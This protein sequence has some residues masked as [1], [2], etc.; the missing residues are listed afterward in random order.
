MP[1]EN[2]RALNRRVRNLVVVTS[3]SA[4]VLVVST[5]AWFI[6]MQTVS[7]SS[8]D[9]EIAAIDGLQLSLDGDTWGTTIAINSGNFDVATY[10]TNTNTWGGTDGLT[11]VST[12]GDIDATTSKLKLYEKSSLTASPGGYRLMTSRIANTADTE[13]DGYVAFDLFV[14]NQSGAEYYSAFEIGNEEAIYLTNDSSVTVAA[15][16]VADTGIENSVRVA[17]AQIGRVNASDETLTTEQ[18]QGISCTDD[19]NVTSICT[20]KAT[21]WEPNDVAHEA[22]AINWYQT[23]CLARTGADVTDEASFAGSC[24]TVVNGIAYDT[25]AVNAPIDWSDNVDVYDGTDYNTYASTTLLSV[26]PDVITDSQKYL[27]GT[28]RPEFIRL[29]PN[30]ITKVRVYVY[31]EGQDIDNYDFSAIGKAI[32]VQFGFTKQRYTEGDIDYDQSNTNEGE[33]PNAATDTTVP[34]IVLADAGSRTFPDTVT[35]GDVVTLSDLL[36]DVTAYDVEMVADAPVRQD[37]AGITYEGTVD[38]SVAGNYQIVYKVTDAAGN[39]GTKVRTI[40]VNEA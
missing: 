3:L 19:A 6:G 28:S 35:V 13:M 34:V 26:A 1:K 14:K 8:F 33:G 17:F 20:R 39:L 11:P 31:I 38:T 27:A 30:S 24:A 4:I 40:T 5:F 29:A 9:V 32:S 15:S 37:L 7:V 12:V 22:N 18:I 21:I 2:K 10:A 25:Y 16:G 36:A 23:S